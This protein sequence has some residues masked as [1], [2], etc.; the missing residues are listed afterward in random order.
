[1]LSIFVLVHPYFDAN[2]TPLIRPKS[3]EIYPEKGLKAHMHRNYSFIV[4]INYHKYL[5]SSLLNDLFLFL[6]HFNRIPISVHLANTPQ[7]SYTLSKKN[8]QNGNN[9]Q[10]AYKIVHLPTGKENY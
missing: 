4:K 10:I 6:G 8:A 9:S 3:M 5:I 7:N 1:M 2:L